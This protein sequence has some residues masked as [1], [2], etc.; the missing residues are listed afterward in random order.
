MA[1]AQDY[2]AYTGPT[3]TLAINGTAVGLGQGVQGRRSYGT[4]G[5]YGI[6]DFMPREHVQNRYE[7]Q[8]T[9]DLF[10]MTKTS[11]MDLGYI[12]LGAEVLSVPLLDIVVSN[13]DKTKIVRAYRKC[14]LSESSENFR[15]N[16]VAGENATFMYLKASNSSN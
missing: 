15:T 8:V 4:Q 2:D 9:L 12:G 5:L 6:G 14:T 3:I 16:A 11:L 7:G 13:S 1:R 10:F